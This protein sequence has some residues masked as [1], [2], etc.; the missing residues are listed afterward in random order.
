MFYWYIE[1][2]GLTTEE[3][4]M[5]CAK[6][7]EVMREGGKSKVGTL[8]VRQS[9]FYVY[10]YG[11]SLALSWMN[12]AFGKA[13]KHGINNHTITAQQKATLHFSCPF[14]QTKQVSLL[15]H[16]AKPLAHQLTHTPVV[17]SLVLGDPMHQSH[18]LSR[19][20]ISHVLSNIPPQGHL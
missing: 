3:L 10:F 15:V 16:V 11:N 4:R 8:R 19:W 20:D 5:L 9:F 12:L 1:I 18:I 7:V 6:I 2:I 14:C 17:I 13:T